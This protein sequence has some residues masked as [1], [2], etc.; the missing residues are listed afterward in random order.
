MGAF[1]L[2]FF[3][4][5]AG[6]RRF[7]FAIIWIESWWEDWSTEVVWAVFQ[8]ISRRG[9]HCHRT[10]GSW[11]KVLGRWLK[12]YHNNKYNVWLLQFRNQRGAAA[13]CQVD[14]PVWWIQADQAHSSPHC[15]KVGSSTS[16]AY[17]F[18]LQQL[19][20]VW[21]RFWEETVPRRFR[22]HFDG[23]HGGQK[24]KTARFI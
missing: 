9:T 1:R 15:H 23:N 7:W 17:H 16:F 18:S 3:F 2:A 21:G 5:S 13:F 14:H 6:C 8:G 19:W 10:I 11:F 24:M 22:N 12:C 20:G 4:L